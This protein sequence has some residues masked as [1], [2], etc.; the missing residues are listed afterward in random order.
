M[1]GLFLGVVLYFLI[2]FAGAVR[3]TRA[4]FMYPED[5]VQVFIFL[6]WPITLG[7]WGLTKT[8]NITATWLDQRQ[9]AAKEAEL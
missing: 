3:Y 5:E 1:V 8:I 4:K 9:G 2:G 6:L 7:W